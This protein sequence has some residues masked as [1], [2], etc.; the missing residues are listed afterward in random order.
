[1]RGSGWLYSSQLDRFLKREEVSSAF[2]HLLVVEHQM[3]VRTERARPHLTWEDSSVVVQR[4]REVVGNEVLARHAKV[5]RIEVPAPEK[6][7]EDTTCLVGWQLV[8]LETFTL[9]SYTPMHIY[10]RQ[11]AIL[12]KSKTRAH[13]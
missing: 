2:R 9:A 13:F 7:I 12:K 6:Y 10:T 3:S 5:H 4:V 11:Y 8:L 1:M